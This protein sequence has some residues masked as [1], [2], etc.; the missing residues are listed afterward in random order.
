MTAPSSP[1]YNIDTKKGQKF[2]LLGDVYTFHIIG[3]E[4]DGKYAVLEITSPSGSC[5][6]LHSHSKETEGFYV[7]DGEFSFQYGDDSSNNKIAVAKPGTFLHLKKNIPH[8]YKNVGNSTGRL[9]FTILP[10]G[11]E[12]FFAEVGVLIDNKETFSPPAIDSIYIMKIVKI[13]DEKYGVKII[14]TVPDQQ[15]KK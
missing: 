7:I 12:N 14:T 1:S 3:A 10:A 5:P 6:L 9:L 8:T 4:T 11:F 15:E 2:W 13:S